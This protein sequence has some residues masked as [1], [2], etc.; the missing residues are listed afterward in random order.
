MMQDYYVTTLSSHS[1]NHMHVTV[2]KR[3]ATPIPRNIISFVL[4]I[5]EMYHS[6][7]QG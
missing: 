3:A 4:A 2:S 6:F 1:A 5:C 7:W